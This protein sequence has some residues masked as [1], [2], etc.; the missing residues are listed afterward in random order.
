MES[1][2]G[3]SIE[4]D[5]MPMIARHFGVCSLMKIT[6]LVRNELRRARTERFPTGDIGF[7]GRHDLLERPC[8]TDSSREIPKTPFVRGASIEQIQDL[9]GLA[10][11][12][13]RLIL[14]S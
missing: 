8:Q 7:F 2:I 3:R 14:F 1:D 13:R 10:F 9:R 4:S 11:A 6:S 5:K 12:S